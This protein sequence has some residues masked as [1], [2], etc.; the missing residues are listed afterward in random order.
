MVSKL[1][2]HPEMGLLLASKG[3]HFY[4]FHFFAEMKLR[5]CAER[6]GYQQNG[7]YAIRLYLK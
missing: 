6:D 4:A 1:S 5:S 2:G 7:A 3:R